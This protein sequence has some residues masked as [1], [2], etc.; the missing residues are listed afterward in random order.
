M[1]STRV[2]T[3]IG[4]S[5]AS[6]IGSGAIR[7]FDPIIYIGTSQYLTCHV[8]FKRTRLSCMMASLPSPIPFR[9]YLLGEQGVGGKCLEFLLKQIIYPDDGFESPPMPADAYQR[10]NRMAQQAPA[11]SDGLVFLPW[12]NGSIVPVEDSFVRGGFFNISL[13]TGRPHL[14][15]AV[16]EGGLPLTTGGPAG[17][18][19]NFWA[20]PSPGFVFPGAGPC[21]SSGHRFMRMCSMSRFIRSRTRSTPRFAAVP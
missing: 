1:P 8:P 20:A 7:D 16:M 21:L 5:N 11:G 19:K 2:V 3:G 14:A 12:L 18:R 15:R 4:D 10:F 13:N 9:Y 6:L 17:E